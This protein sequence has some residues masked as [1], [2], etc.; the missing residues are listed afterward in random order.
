MFRFFTGKSAPQLAIRYLSLLVCGGP[1][2]RFFETDC[3]QAVYNKWK[4][5]SR[6]MYRWPDLRFW[7]HRA[8]TFCES[9]IQD[10]HQLYGIVVCPNKVGYPQNCYLIFLPRSIWKAIS[11]SKNFKSTF[12]A[13]LRKSW[14]NLHLIPIFKCTV[15]LNICELCQKHLIVGIAKNK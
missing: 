13:Y 10:I 15:N 14:R 4:R 2:F 6:D 3:R 7:L 9:Q 1:V 5:K 11:S 8:F 12:A